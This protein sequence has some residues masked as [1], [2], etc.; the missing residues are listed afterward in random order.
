MQR[1]ILIIDDHD[2]LASALDE[3]FTH[4]GHNVKIVENRGEA[5][6]IRDLSTFDLLI[7][8]LDLVPDDPTYA[9]GASAFCPEVKP[10]KGKQEHIRHLRSVRQ[11][12]TR[13]F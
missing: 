2:D 13:S 10:T 1:Q 6:A 3:V 7:T 11:L 9:N 5:M 12:P 8:D 4:T